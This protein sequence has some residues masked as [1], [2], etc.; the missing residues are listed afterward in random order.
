MILLFGMQSF[1]ISLAMGSAFKKAM[2]EFSERCKMERITL[3][4][5]IWTEG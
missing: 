1:A 5:R 4:K 3:K 2:E